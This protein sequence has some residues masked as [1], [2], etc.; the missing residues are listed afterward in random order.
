VDLLVHGGDWIA[1][2]Q[3]QLPRTWKMFRKYL[4]DLPILTVNGNHDFWDRDYWGSPV[5][6]RSY[7]RHPS[8]MSLNEMFLQHKDWALEHNIHLLRDKP[9]IKEDTIFYGFN[10]WYGHSN[11][12]TNDSKYMNPLYESAP[13][14]LYLSNLA[15]KE[16]DKI[17]LDINTQHDYKNKVCVTHFPPYSKDSRYEIYCANTSF[18]NPIE[19]NFDLLIVGHSHQTEDWNYKSLRIVNP[20][21]YFDPMSGGYNKPKF[22]IIEI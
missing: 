22:V 14:S 19:E 7:C 13:T 18:I 11:P 21:T 4:G 15:Y 16:L 8:G 17:I 10:G 3:H 1:D 12:P 20:G 6:K 5:R 9:F 2:N